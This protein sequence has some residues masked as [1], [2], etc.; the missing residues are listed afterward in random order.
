MGNK[1]F[2]SYKFNDNSVYPLNNDDKTTARNYVDIIENKLDLLDHKYK[3]ESNDEDLS[4]YK[5]SYIWELLKPRIY[6]SS[7]TIVIISPEMKSPSRYEKYHWIPWEIS[8]SLKET[9]RRDRTSH[10]NAVFS[11]VLPYKDNSYK[12]FVRTCNECNYLCNFYN[13]YIIFP[14][15]YSNMFNKKIQNDI[16]CSANKRY[17]PD[18]DEETSYIFAVKWN[19]FISDMDYSIKRAID[20]QNKISDYNITTELKKK[21]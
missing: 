3:G 11:V 4:K 8:Y 19:D 7:I 20:L 1:I 15:M 2:V 18:P 14:V 21:W 10:S 5:E 17:Y 13:S 6:D 12:Y 9:T 16:Y